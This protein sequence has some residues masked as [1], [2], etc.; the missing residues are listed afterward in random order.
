MGASMRRDE[1]VG[2]FPELMVRALHT[3]MRDWLEAREELPLLTEEVTEDELYTEARILYAALQKV[4]S[5]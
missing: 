5:P 4:V 2:E 1:S 3:A